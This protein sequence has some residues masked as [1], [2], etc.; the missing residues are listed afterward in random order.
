[1]LI[2]IGRRATQPA[3]Q[4]K[5]LHDIIGSGLILAHA[6]AI[7]QVELAILAS[8]HYQMGMRPVLVGK[9]YGTNPT[10]VLVFLAEHLLIVGRE[11]VANHQVIAG[12]REF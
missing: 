7:D 9:E 12:E 3:L 4:D 6:I 1:V 10:Q 2:P 11:V 5:R 8:G